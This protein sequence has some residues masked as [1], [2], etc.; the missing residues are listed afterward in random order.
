MEAVTKDE[1]EQVIKILK[2]SLKRLDN[3]LNDSD[4]IETHLMHQSLT[5]H[6]ALTCF[7]VELMK[8]Q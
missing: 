2:K 3:Q 5:L 4:F 1:V 8:M 6:S 7:E